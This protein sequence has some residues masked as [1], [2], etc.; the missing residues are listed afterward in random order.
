MGAS[1]AV[2]QSYLC[3]RFHL[4][5]T[6][7]LKGEGEL[8]DPR[9]AGVPFPCDIFVPCPTTPTSSATTPAWPELVEFGGSDNEQS[10]RAAFQN[11]LAAYCAAHR[12][13]LAL[14]PELRAAAVIPDGTV[15]DALRM[16]RGHWEAK[17]SHDDLD[18]EIQAKF[19]AATPATT[20]YSRIRGW[21]C[22]SRNGEQAM[23][24][25]MARPADLHRLIH[26][27]SRLRTA[28]N[29]GIPPGAATV[30][31]RP[32]RRAGQP[33]PGRGRRRGRQPALPGQGHRTSSNCAAA[34]SAPPSPMPTCAKCCCSTS[35]RRTFS[36]ACSPKT[37]ST[38][39]T[40]SPAS[41]PPWSRPFS[42]GDVRPPGHRPPA[43]LLRRN[44]AGRRRNRRVRRKAAVPQGRLRGLLQG[45]QPGRRR[46]PRRGLHPQTRSWISS[47]AAPDYLLHRHFGRG[48]ADDN[49]QIL[50]PA[51]GTGTFV[52][53]LIDYL[54][55]DRLGA[56]VPAR[57]PRQRGR[58]TALL[59]R[60]PEHR[61]QL[62]RADGPLPGVPQP[63]FRGTRW[64]TWTGSRPGPVAARCS[65]RPLSTSAA[66]PRKTGSAVQEQNE[67]PI[68]V[69]IGNPPYN[70]SQSN[71]NEFNP[72]RPYAEIDRRIRDTYVK[73]GTAQKTHQYDMYKRFIRWASDR[74]DD[75]RHYRLCHQPRISGLTAGR[76]LSQSYR[77][78]IQ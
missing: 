64:T 12:E 16:T 21:P 20:S 36:C 19:N 24:V 48:L 74:L 34:P 6:L 25:D 13:R 9:F 4:T 73:E 75:R 33:A 11:C 10:I 68:S 14:V 58:H 67:K 51:T 31:G 78:R 26:P 43:G 70:D 41:S 5:P 17:D 15:K 32:A 53:G 23:R 52:T 1:P 62:P 61:V 3:Q 39:K 63:L 8:K 69:I 50:D 71:W 60:Q 56:Q 49:V 59:H 2:R 55:L 77:R 38:A 66:C 72:N 27:L 44:R 76:R 7:S 30:Q 65:A 40:T 35:S 22:C 46:P 47:S 42:T 54:P 29:R 28:R 18:A 57:N 37:S 45:V